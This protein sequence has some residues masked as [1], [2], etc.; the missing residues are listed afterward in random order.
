MQ[1]I[2]WQPF[3]E[4][5]FKKAKTENKPILLSISASWCHWCHRMDHDSFEKTAVVEQ[6]NRDFIP[7]RVDS[8]ERPDINARYNAGGWPTVVIMDPN[9]IPFRE[10]LYL[11]ESD[12]KKFLSDGHADYANP[13]P[14]SSAIPIETKQAPPFSQLEST[15]DEHRTVEIEVIQKIKSLFDPQYGGFGIQPKFPQPEILRFL[16][17]KTEKNKDPDL[18]KI[19]LTT[20]DALQSRGLFDK[21]EGGF[22]RYCTT[23]EWSI[24]HSEKMLEDNAQLVEIFGRAGNRFKKPDYIKTA[25]KTMDYL[26]KNLKDPVSGLF[27]GSQ[28]AD[29][30]YYSLSLSERQQKTPPTSQ[31]TQFLGGN[32]FMVR[33][34]LGLGK[35]EDARVLLQKITAIFYRENH[36]R[37]STTPGSN[38]FWLEDAALLLDAILNY[39]ETNPGQ[40]SDE[41]PILAGLIIRKFFSA[42]QHAFADI[43]DSSGHLGLLA[44]PLYPIFGNS[45]MI[46][47]LNRVSRLTGNPEW[48]A[49]AK[50]TF[51]SFYSDYKKHGIFA[52]TYALA[53]SELKNA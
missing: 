40:N 15:P 9:G 32:A 22:F 42:D 4:E 14:N 39:E 25:Q 27:N 46:R 8:N 47:N 34:F 23:R 2:Q 48:N 49:Y 21:E 7:I 45:L 20:L 18:E 30:K 35:N 52:A 44:E 38:L 43:P 33:A 11:N 3:F 51:A 29:E 50:K 10:T 6:V 5:A 31:E 16:L 13:D 41:A 24:P 28:T 17:F 36:V 19:L 37:H 26:E 53:A 12:F 1:T